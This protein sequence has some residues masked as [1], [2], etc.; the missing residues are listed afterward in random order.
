MLIDLTTIV[1]LVLG[2]LAVYIA[3]KRPELGSALGVGA[4]V[5]TL[6]ILL[7]QGQDQ[8]QAASQRPLPATSSSPTG[9][10]CTKH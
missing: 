8:G 3:H 6:L 9:Q 10:G 1:V 5:I 4:V 7:L 2:G